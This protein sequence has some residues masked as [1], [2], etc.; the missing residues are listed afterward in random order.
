[1]LGA[2]LVERIVAKRQAAAIQMTDHV[3]SSCRIHIDADGTGVFRGSAT[4][5]Q[6]AWHIAPYNLEIVFFWI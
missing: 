3:G 6:N 2:Y 4:D 1:M 5:I